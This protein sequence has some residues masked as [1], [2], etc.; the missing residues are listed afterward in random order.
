MNKI[1]CEIIEDMLPLYV[2][3]LAS[4]PTEEMVETHLS[5]CE[6]CQKKLKQLQTDIT[7]PMETESEPMKGIQRK[8]K[9]RNAIIAVISGLVALVLTILVGVHLGSPILIDNYEDA[10]TVETDGNGIVSLI[11]SDKVAG[12]NLEGWSDEEVGIYSLSCWDTKW[13]QLFAKEKECT[14][15]LAD[16]DISQLYYYS[17]Q[18]YDADGD[19]LIYDTGE[20]AFSGGCLTIPS[21]VL[22]VYMVLCVILLLIGIVV[23][24]VLRKKDTKFISQKITLF[25]ASYVIS[26]LLILAGKGDIYNTTYYFSG[27]LFMTIVLYLLLLYVLNCTVWK[28]KM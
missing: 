5:T 11:L 16:K 8:M 2:E 27:I 18:T 21:G 12:Y 15:S 7:I 3:H 23:S 1:N 6:S 28:K 10:V 9:K 25:P 20:E 19:I 26:S 24:F 14:I 4:K 17:P 22:Y 13:N